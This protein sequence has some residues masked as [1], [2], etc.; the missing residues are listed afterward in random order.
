MN[1]TQLRQHRR[2]VRLSQ[3]LDGGHVA[4]IPSTRVVRVNKF[5]FE[6]GT[7]T[8]MYPLV[9]GTPLVTTYVPRRK[10]NTP[11]GLIIFPRHA[12]GRVTGPIVNA[13]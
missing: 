13:A 8:T 4:V 3:R 1:R 10:Q 9:I 7:V 5:A 2:E 12:A 6:G 11:E